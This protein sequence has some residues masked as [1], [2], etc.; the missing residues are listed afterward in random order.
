MKN[1][2]Y[3]DIAEFINKSEQQIKWYKSNNSDM[4]E[5]LKVGAFCKKNNISIEKIKKCVEL[6]ELAK[7]S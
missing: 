1:V 5:L 4:L 2:T 7:D 3:K 6:Q